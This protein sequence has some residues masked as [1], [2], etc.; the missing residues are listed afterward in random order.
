MNDNIHL[1]VRGN[2]MAQ[3]GSSLDPA[4]TTTVVNN[5][6]HSPVSQYIVTINWVSVSS[7]KDLYTCRVY[8]E[9]LLTYGHDAEHIHLNGAFCYPDQGGIFSPR[10]TKR[11]LETR[12]TEP[13][14]ADL[15]ERRDRDIR[16]RTGRSMQRAPITSSRSR[17]SD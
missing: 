4:D 14:Q 2:L 12:V 13:M 11:H 5:L 15:Q 9:T 1:S 3:D 8:L 17:S 16:P 7:T 10:P 6:H